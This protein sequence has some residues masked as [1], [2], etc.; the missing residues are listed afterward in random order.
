MTW[1]PF[2]AS[3]VHLLIYCWSDTNNRGSTVWV[4]RKVPSQSLIQVHLCHL[5]LPAPYVC[6][7][8][9]NLERKIVPA[10][11]I[12][13]EGIKSYTVYTA[14]SLACSECSVN[15]SHYYYCHCPIF[16]SCYEDWMIHAHQGPG[17]LCLVQSSCQQSSLLY[18]KA[19][20]IWQFY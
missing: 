5:L 18:G 4:V 13:E 16:H 3:S 2:K 11:R 9:S 15:I 7:L 19:L 10:S 12:T 1:S 17:T 8:S 6:F 14:L 20:I